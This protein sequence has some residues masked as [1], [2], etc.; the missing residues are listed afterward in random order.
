MKNYIYQKFLLQCNYET[1]NLS[2]IPQFHGNLESISR[3]GEE[4]NL[5]DL[6]VPYARRI[7]LTDMDVKIDTS[8]DWN[9]FI[10]GAEELDELII[11][12]DRE[13]SQNKIIAEYRLATL[14][15]YMYHIRQ[16]CSHVKVFYCDTAN[17]SK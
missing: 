5:F 16:D 3:Y 1:I 17:E 8:D 7:S 10:E 6:G 4:Y 13:F 2:T 15:A 11:Y 12:N 14:K 9:A